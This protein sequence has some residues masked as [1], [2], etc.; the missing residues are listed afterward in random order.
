[1]K[2]RVLAYTK[3]LFW[4]YVMILLIVV[5]IKFNGSIY[6]LK[7]RILYCKSDR[8]LGYWNLNLVPMRTMKHQLKNINEWWALRNVIRN[9]ILFVPLGFFLPI[10]YTK[11]R[12]FWRLFVTSLFFIISIEVF[13]LITMLGSCDIDDIILNMLGCILGYILFLLVNQYISRGQV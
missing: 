7:D 10:L 8:A 6:E 13:Q 1:M 11:C 9:I 12:K 2:K 3:I 4:I 5:V